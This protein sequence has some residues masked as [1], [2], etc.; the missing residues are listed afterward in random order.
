VSCAIGPVSSSVQPVAQRLLDAENRL[1]TTRN[2]RIWCT[3]WLILC[4]ATLTVYFR[5]GDWPYFSH[6]RPTSCVDIGWLWITGRFAVLHEAA[7]VFDYTSFAKAQADLFGAGNC[8]VLASFPYPPTLL[9]FSYPLGLV[10]FVTAYALWTIALTV[11]FLGAIYA[12]LRRPNALLAAPPVRPAAVTLYL[13]HTAFLTAGLFGFALTMLERRPLMAGFLLALLT[14][15]P[16]FGMLIPVALLASRNWRALV[17]AM[18][19]SLALAGAAALAFAGGWSSFLSNLTNRNA[20][21]SPDPAFQ[22]QHISLYGVLQS[23]GVGTSTALAA[24]AA[25]VLFLT[26]AVWV[27]WSK[28]IVHPMRASLLCVAS[29]L[30]SPYVLYYDLCMPAIAFAFLVSDGLRR[31]FLPGERTVIF[32]CW[33]ALNFPAHSAPVISCLVLVLLLCRRISALHQ[34][35]ASHTV[36]RSASPAQ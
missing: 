32:V 19:F 26:G 35:D 14:Y 10:S 8:K 9:F 31:G 20:N 22:L 25:L 29:F 13:G 34:D 15:K 18:F 11:L 12:I 27:F 28:P 21:L 2:A 17:S 30:A 6:N 4:A 16:Q 5:S 7:R 36:P 24:Q 3:A 33:I 23:A 1:F